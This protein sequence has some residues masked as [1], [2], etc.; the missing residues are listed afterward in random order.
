MKP[1]LLEQWSQSWVRGPFRVRESLSGVRERNFL[2]T[3]FPL[4]IKRSYLT[5]IPLYVAKHQGFALIA[6]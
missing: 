6:R 3:I 5:F 4:T 2:Y 1:N